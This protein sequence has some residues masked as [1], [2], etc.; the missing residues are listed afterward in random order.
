MTLL[1]VK[2][3]QNGKVHVHREVYVI[4]VQPG[5]GTCSDD[6]AKVSIPRELM[7]CPYIARLPV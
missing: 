5:L 2:K 6:L 3:S 4:R 1:W 7:L